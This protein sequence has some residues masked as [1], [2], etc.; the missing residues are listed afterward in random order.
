M[1]AID[2][3]Q[4]HQHGFAIGHGLFGAAECEAFVWGGGMLDL[5]AGRGQLNGF[6]PRKSDNRERTHN[7][8]HYD[9][10]A[11]QWLIYM[12]FAMMSLIP[13]RA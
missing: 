1:S 11:L 3:D 5:Q 13:S 4:Y 6:E 10:F 7:Q 9:N 2:L 12:L 8:N